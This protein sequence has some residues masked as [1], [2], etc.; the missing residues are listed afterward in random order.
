MAQLGFAA[1]SRSR[2]APRQDALPELPIDVDWC[3]QRRLAAA[4]GEDGLQQ[5]ALELA[6][7]V[8]QGGPVGLMLHHAD[9]DAL[10]RVL[11]RRLLGATREHAGTRWHLMRDLLALPARPTPLTP[12]L[13]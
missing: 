3:K 10:D 9:M 7:R 13:S 6:R 2:G 1:L 11:L 4:Q 5:I 12:A 8:A